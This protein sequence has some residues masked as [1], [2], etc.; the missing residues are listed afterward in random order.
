M[1]GGR[2]GRAGG[3]EG[4]PLDRELDGLPTELRRR[5]WTGRIEAALFASPEPL[6][7]GRLARLVG[8]GVAVEG[9]LGEIREAA[10]GRGW[11]LV[12]AAGG[13]MLRTRPRFADAVMAVVDTRGHGP[14]LSEMDMAVLWAVATRQPVDRAG[15]REIFGADVSRDLLA[16]L[17]LTGLVAT[18]PRA[19]RPGA[20]HTYVTTEEF[21]VTFG[22]RSLRDLQDMEGV[23]HPL[24]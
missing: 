10:E 8:E 13:W 21:L 1:S 7:A 18:G 9:L 4:A 23:G 11:E 15:L 3:G 5:E 20:P 24:C 22:L 2:R 16:R 14:E 12:E 17:R 6:P 19:P